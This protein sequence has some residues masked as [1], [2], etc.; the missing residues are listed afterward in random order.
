MA[1]RKAVDASAVN[2]NDVIAIPEAI[3]PQHLAPDQGS[4][5]VGDLGLHLC[6][7]EAR[8]GHIQ[9]VALRDGG[10]PEEL[11]E[12]GC[13]RCVVAQLI[14]YGQETRPGQDG[15]SRQCYEAA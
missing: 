7:I 3:A 1:L 10:H 5:Q 12:I 4:G 6:R 15:R 9:G 2:G 11:G 14:A 13:R 8:V